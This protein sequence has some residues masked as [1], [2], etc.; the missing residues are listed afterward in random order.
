MRFF[1]WFR[2]S[3]CTAML[4]GLPL[5]GIRAMGSDIGPY[6]EFPPVTRYVAHAPF[7]W[8]AFVLIGALDLLMLLGIVLILK[9]SSLKRHTAGVKKEAPFPGWGRWGVVIMLAG[10]VLAWTRLPWFKPMQEHTF[11]IPWAGYILFV[12]ALCLKRS[13]RCLLTDAPAKFAILF[14]ASATFWWFFEYLNRFVQNWYYVHVGEFGQAGYVLLASM[15]FSTVLPA[16]LSTHR[17]LLTFDLFNSR[18]AGGP[19]VHLPPGRIP[20]ALS[21]LAA[22]A[23]LTLIG[24]YPDFLYPLVW[25]A[26]LL[27][28]VGLQSFGDRPTLLTELCGGGWRLIVSPA[29]AALICGFFW[30]M[31]N[32]YSLTRW[33]YAIPFVDRYHIFAMPL[34]GYGGYLPF[35]LECVV[36]GQLVVGWNALKG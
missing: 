1:D 34:L 36:I 26:P 15:A 12:N 32:F 4:I 25:F 5:V 28:I 31:W 13:G 27:I 6:L 16:V 18:L 8:T 20:A 21:L 23:G 30:E 33:E 10:W 24:V 11:C 19:V 7:S 17:L 22:A 9:K 29:C 35:G 2:V 3:F 14:P